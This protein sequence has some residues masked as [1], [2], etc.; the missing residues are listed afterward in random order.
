MKAIINY[1]NQNSDRN[2][3]VEIL[4]EEFIFE[5]Y[6]L[7]EAINKISTIEKVFNLIDEIQRKSQSQ[8]RKSQ[9]QKR[10]LQSKNDLQNLQTD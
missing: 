6:C 2:V 9:S 5:C 10:K 4:D 1:C 7:Q 3:R 8:K